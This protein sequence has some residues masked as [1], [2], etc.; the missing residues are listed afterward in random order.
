MSTQ[1]S[2]LQELINEL[3]ESPHSFAIGIGLPTA[4]TIYDIL[5]DKRAISRYVLKRIVETYPH[6]NPDWLVEGRLPK[7][8]TGKKEKEPPEILNEKS[9][10]YN[11]V[12]AECKKKDDENKDL[13]LKVIE[14]QEL[15]IECLKKVNA[16]A[17]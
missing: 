5:K 1:G 12:C 6:V 4:A 14:L 13:R 16:L 10:K 15:Y 17:G 3:L 2:R 7:L 9:E 11:L 8:L